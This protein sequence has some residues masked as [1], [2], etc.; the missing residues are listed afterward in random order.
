MSK[1]VYVVDYWVPFPAS[2]YG[3]LFVFVA[4]NDKQVIDMFVED[5]IDWDKLDSPDYKER[6]AAVVKKAKK[7]PA[8]EDTKL[9]YVDSFTT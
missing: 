7:I 6:I 4:E 9:G 8:S 2:E 1:Y 3:G 5:A